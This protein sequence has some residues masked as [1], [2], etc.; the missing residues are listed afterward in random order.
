MLL[1]LISK[2]VM[3]MKTSRKKQFIFVV[4]GTLFLF[5][6]CGSDNKKSDEPDVDV[7]TRVKDGNGKAFLEGGVLVNA[8]LDYTQSQLEQALDNYE[9]ETDYS[10]YYDNHTISSNKANSGFNLLIHTNRTVECP[11]F[12]ESSRIRNLT[13]AGK[14]IMISHEEPAWSSSLSFPYIFTVVSLDM[15]DNGGRII[16]DMRDFADLEGFDN[17]S[18]YTRMILRT[19]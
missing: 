7:I 11:L 5:S 9:W 13:V 3:I 8:N 19:K 18:L 1:E 6:S 2:S 16:I 17:N 14:Q 4:L 10:F 12:P 15:N